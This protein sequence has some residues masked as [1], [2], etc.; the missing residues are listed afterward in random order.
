MNIYDYKR[1]VR[2]MG[3]VTTED[4]AVVISIMRKDGAVVTR[5]MGDEQA[6]RKV[7]EALRVLPFRAPEVRTTLGEK[8]ECDG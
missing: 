5:N 1:V 8:E 7:Y 6:R 2:T 4:Q 3:D